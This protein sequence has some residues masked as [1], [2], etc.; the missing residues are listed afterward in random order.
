MRPD[1]KKYADPLIDHYQNRYWELFNAGDKPRDLRGV[2]E[3]WCAAAATTAYSA[4]LNELPYDFEAG[5][6]VA[7]HEAITVIDTGESSHGR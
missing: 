2:L 6:V 4:R 3:W 5:H 7:Y 1:Q